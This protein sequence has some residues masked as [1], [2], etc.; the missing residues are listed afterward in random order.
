MGQIAAKYSDECILTT[1]NCRS[2]DPREIIRQIKEG[3]N[4]DTKYIEILD[5]AEAIRY[6]IF[7]SRKGYYTNNR[8]GT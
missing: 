4:K 1:D 5:R 2:E 3:F 8:Q 7:N 6:A